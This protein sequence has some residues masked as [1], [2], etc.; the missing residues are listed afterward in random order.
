[1]NVFV[2]PVEREGLLRS[3][4][5]L[6][7]EHLVVV[8]ALRF[9]MAMVPVMVML[10]TVI[11]VLVGVV[12]VVVVAVMVGV[13]LEVDFA[14]HLLEMKVSIE[15]ILQPQHALAALVR[16]QDEEGSSGPARFT[17]EGKPAILIEPEA[18]CFSI[19]SLDKPLAGQLLV[20]RRTVV[21]M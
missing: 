11:V 20:E 8:L 18:A 2:V 1:M 19:F 12:P 6:D 14:A 7:H 9:A 21:R 17:L 16:P 15:V 3:R 10:L 5:R 13:G 4:Q